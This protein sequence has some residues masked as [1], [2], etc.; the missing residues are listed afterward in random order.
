MGLLVRELGEFG[1]IERLRA[2]VDRVDARSIV[3]IGDD[4]AVVRYDRPVVMTTDALVEGVHFR[5]DLIDMVSVGYKS[6]VASLS[7]VAAMGGQPLHAMVAL[8]LPFSEQVERLEA[9]YEGL[10]DAC[11]QYDVAVVGG[12]VVSTSGPL[13]VT[14]SVT[15]ELLGEHP[16]LRSG[17]KV[18]DLVFVTGDVGGS[19]AYLHLRN[20]ASSLLLSEND[21][22]ILQQKHIRPVPQLMAGRIFAQNAGCTSLN[23][24]SDG[25]SSE[26]HEIASA[27]GV[28]LMIEADRIPTLPSVRHY[29]RLAGV[30]ALDFALYGGEDYQLV[31]TIDRTS[32]G[33]FL[34]L[35]QAYGVRISLIGQVKRGESGVYLQT[36]SGLKEIKK[37]GYDHFVVRDEHA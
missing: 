20:Q 17:A 7:D 32:A 4:A 15:G 3:N 27:S 28:R 29:A 1:L 13:V 10:A 12:D 31:G 14:V 23:D 5:D 6:L 24:V 11:R 26:L 35:M 21:V 37:K 30:D 34:P 9:I 36:N 16:L 2:I 25:L 22:W 18:G 19:A 33:I 8:A